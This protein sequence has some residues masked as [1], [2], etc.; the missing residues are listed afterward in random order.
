MCPYLPRSLPVFLSLIVQGPSAEARARASF[1]TS[2]VGVSEPAA[3]SQSI[4]VFGKVSGGEPGY[5]ETA[6]MLAVSAMILAT[7]RREIPGV[8]VS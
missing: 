7:R 6:K 8:F 1:T 3:G 2:L 5:S 4:K